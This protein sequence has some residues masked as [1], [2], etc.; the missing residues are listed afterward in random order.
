MTKQSD[1]PHVMVNI[2][3]SA[4]GKIASHRRE[5]YSL[6]SPADRL[7]MDVLRAR[8]DAVVIGSRTLALDGWAIRVRDRALRDKR[9][10]RRGSPHPLNVVL[11]SKLD[12]PT[13]VQFFQHGKT[14]RLI[15]TT[16][17]APASRVKRFSRVADVEVMRRR[18]I[19]PGAVLEALRQRGCR[20][21]LLEGGGQLNFSFFQQDLVDE[22][23][24]TITPRIIGG[25]TAPTPV[26]GKGFLWKAQRR[27][28]LVSCRR[29][30]DEV[31]LRYR[32]IRP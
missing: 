10:K 20:K 14:E 28:K 15:F 7:L 6:G 9:R 18:R 23:Y 29:R 8:A 26:D 11:S 5:T 3:A 27:L 22:L 25:A 2:A 12:L 1:K 21:V 30:E 24:L 17:D 19:D 16:R 13:S 32:A 4:D 31:F